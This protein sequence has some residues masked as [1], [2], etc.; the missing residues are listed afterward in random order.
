MGQLGDGKQVLIVL[1]S[2][3]LNVFSDGGRK[4]KLEVGGAVVGQTV[5]HE[6]GERLRRIVE[7]AECPL[8]FAKLLIG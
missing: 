6:E 4:G 5:I 3:V 1:P 8:G 7:T 2:L